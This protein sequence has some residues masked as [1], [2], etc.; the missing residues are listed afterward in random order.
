MTIPGITERAVRDNVEQHRYEIL[1]GGEL[2]GYLSY[3]TSDERMLITSTQV[4]PEHRG[5]GLAGELVRHA[6]DDVRRRGQ[7]MLTTCWYVK[8]WVAAHPDYRDLQQR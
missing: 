5:H 3:R 8:E 6:L 7:S 2:A 1:I 4:F